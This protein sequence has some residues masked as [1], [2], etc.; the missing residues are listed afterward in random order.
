MYIQL[1]IAVGIRIKSITVHSTIFMEQQPLFGQG[2]LIIEASR[3]HSGTKIGWNPLEEWSARSRYLYQTSQNTRHTTMSPV[4]FKPTIPAS[5]QPQTHADRAATWTHKI[6]VPTSEYT[7]CC[8][9]IKTIRLITFNS[10][11]RQNHKHSA[12]WDTN[13]INVTVH[14]IRDYS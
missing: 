13:F 10:R 4:G 5:K 11:N 8:S 14:I 12:V 6:S 9:V 1:N 3:S 2:F 7:H